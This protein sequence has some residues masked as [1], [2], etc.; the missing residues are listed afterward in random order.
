MFRHPSG[1]QPRASSHARDGFPA[2]HHYR[3]FSQE[4]RAILAADKRSH[5]VFLAG[6]ATGEPPLASLIVQAD[7]ARTLEESTE[8]IGP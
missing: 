3:H 8:R 4:V 5:A 2:S 7:L 6:L 1:N